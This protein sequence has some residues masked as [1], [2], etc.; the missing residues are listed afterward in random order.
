MPIEITADDLEIEPAAFD[1]IE[2]ER[3]ALLKQ[4]EDL[5]AKWE[6]A[7]SERDIANQRANEAI[8]ER[9]KAIGNSAYWMG[10]YSDLRKAFD[11][12]YGYAHAS[13]SK[14]RKMLREQLEKTEAERENAMAEATR[15]RATN[16]SLREALGELIDLMQGVT[17]GDYKPDSFTL[18]PAKDALAAAPSDSKPEFKVMGWIEKGS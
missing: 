15:L 7:D 6:G 13:E 1:N 16:N 5:Q 12:L 2:D 9:K 17:E 14:Q 10:A 4:V 3:D 8:A 11:R 18:Q